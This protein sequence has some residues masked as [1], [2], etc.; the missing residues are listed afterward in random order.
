MAA[1]PK[2]LPIH[3][4]SYLEGG[5]IIGWLTTIDHKRVAVMYLASALF[6]MAFGGL[7]AMAIRVQLWT[8]RQSRAIGGDLQRLLHDARDDDDLPGRHAAAARIPRQLPDPSADRCARR[9]VP[10]AQCAELLARS[11]RG[12]PAA[13]RLDSRRTS[14]RRM[15]RLREPDRAVLHARPRDRLVGGRSAR[16]GH[17]DG[18]HR[19]ELSHDDH[20]DAR[21]G[22]D[23]H[24]HADVHLG[25]VGDVDP[26]SDRVSGAH[27]RS[28]LFAL[29]SFLRHALST[30][31]PPAPRRSSGSI[32]SG[33]SATPKCTSWRCRPLGSSRKS[34]RPSRASRCS[35]IR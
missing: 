13:S 15:V 23:V 33:C 9:R 28:D 24:A 11:R 4:P 10:A 30:S 8:S 32:C 19:P 21:A 12:N 2:P 20:R 18:A 14:R 35:A 17:V 29:R 5:G 27:D 16:I 3:Q 31:H 6:F 7:E 1:Q 26:D 22:H 34:F 25:D